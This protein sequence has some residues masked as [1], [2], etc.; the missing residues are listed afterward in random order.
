MPNPLVARRVFTLFFFLFC[1]TVP[2]VSVAPAQT[3]SITYQGKFTE[4]GQPANGSFDLQ[5]RLFDALGGGTQQGDAVT[6]EDVVVAN[7]V[8]TVQLDFGACPTCFNGAARFLEISVRPGANTG[9]FTLLTPR[10]PVQSTPYAIRSL[11]AG[12]ADNATQLGGVAAA[13]YLQGITHDA[14][15]TGN[16]TTGAPLSVVSSGWSLTGNA[17]TNPATNFLGTTDNQPMV[18]RVNGAELMR[19]SATGRIGIGLTAP[20]EKLHLGDGNFLL[21]GGGETAVKIKRD[22]TISGGPSGTSRNPIF[23]LGRIIQAGDGD[24]EFRF[25]YSDDNTPPRAVFEFD[26]KGIVASVKPARGSHFEGFISNTDPEP[27]FRLNS[28]PK[29]RL[30]M[31]DGG[32]TPVDVAVQREAASTLTF[33]TGN[34]ERVRIDA[35]GNLGL[36][37]I[38]PTQKLSVTGNAALT[39][40]IDSLGQSSKIRFHYDTFADLPSPA[41][42]HGMFAHV[43]ADAKAYFAHAGAWVPLANEAHTHTAADITSGI[44]TTARG[45]TGLTASGTAGNYLRSDGNTWNSSSLLGADIIGTIPAASVPSGNGSYIQNTTSQQAAA[46][47]NINGDGTAGGTLSGNIINAATQFNLNGSRILSNAGTNN[48]FVGFGIRTEGG[49]NVIVTAGQHQPGGGDGN[50]IFGAL[51]GNSGSGNSIFGFAAG[52]SGNGSDNAFFGARAGDHSNGSNNAFFGANAGVFGNIGSNN[53]CLGSI[54]GCGGI[55]AN[56]NTAVG[57]GAGVGSSSRMSFNTAIGSGA[58]IDVDS[59]MGDSFN[60][61]I[62]AN[63]HVSRLPSQSISYATAIGAGAQVSTSNTVVLGRGADTVQVPGALTVSG[64]TTITLGAPGTGQNLCINNQNVVVDCTTSSARYK[65]NITPLRAGLAEINRLRPVNFTW[66]TTNETDFG[67]IAEEVAEITPI[68]SAYDKDGA[69]KGVRYDKLPIVLVNA[70]KEQQALIQQQQQQLR[71]Q[72]AELELLRQAVCE[73]QPRAAA[74]QP[75]AARK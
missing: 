67:L 18:F 20:G 50:S 71:R 56:N 25:L 64:N 59:P 69:L 24:P 7:G 27:I 39:G 55:E 19:L 53:T 63:A 6:L 10:Q 45:G 29:M 8:F 23:E 1:V 21:E 40:T 15:L 22:F 65:T 51:A 26:R 17:G 62:G 43:H 3:G 68:L 5:F 12:S 58:A 4:A 46:N 41:T 47:F 34:A 57:Y 30:E 60:T 16:G 14:T 9:T 37:T 61:A 42:Y 73:L 48:L 72:E 49:N 75:P 32:A 66:K 74:C 52:L 70:V 54:S 28:F 2:G 33:L 35:N 44:L 13:N 11:S 31:G 38:N 36:G